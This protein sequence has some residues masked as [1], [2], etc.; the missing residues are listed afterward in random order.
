[1]AISASKITVEGDHRDVYAHFDDEG[2]IDGHPICPPTE[3]AVTEVLDWV[4]KKLDRKANEV[5]A[6]IEPACG[7]ATIE[8]IAINAVMAGCKPEYM[9]VLIAAVECL[10][11]NREHLK[12][13]LM[14]SH[15][16]SAF[17]VVNG[18]IRQSLGIQSGTVGRLGGSWR[19]NAAI[20]RAF[21]FI[22]SNIGSIKRAGD[23]R[24]FGWV[25]AY[26]Y[27]LGENEEDS[28][29]DPFHVENGFQ[30]DDSV[31]TVM[32]P[33]PPHHVEAGRW[34]Y[35]AQELLQGFCDSMNTVASRGSYGETKPIFI[36]GQDHARYVAEAGFSKADVKKF[37]YE[38]ARIPLYRYP[39]AGSTGFSNEYQKF[40]SHSPHV[41]VPMVTDP[42][43]FIIMVM[44]GPGPNSWYVPGHHSGATMRKIQCPVE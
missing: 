25:G 32:V 3:E 20:G 21:R 34:K 16:R 10:K 28:P 4:E 26:D 8:K 37:Y 2:W 15:T 38:H 35:S 12:V 27:C 30:K 43:E 41:G 5:V 7:E 22:V 13:I 44:G 36:F 9:P 11:Q 6:V 17:L 1:M 39:K 42:N 40:F 19:A 23:K 14:G 18:P 24:T 33:E 29:W 31:V